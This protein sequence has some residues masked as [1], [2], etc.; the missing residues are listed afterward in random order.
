M[1]MFS[2]FDLLITLVQHSEYDICLLIMLK[3]I[4]FLKMDIFLNLSCCSQREVNRLN[5]LDLWIK[6]ILHFASVLQNQI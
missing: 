3:Y 4:T 6:I 2:D 5:C 1:L